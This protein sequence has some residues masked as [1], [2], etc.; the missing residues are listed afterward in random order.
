LVVAEIPLYFESDRRIAEAEVWV[1]YVDQETQVKRLMER[2][3][4]T[5]QRPEKG[6][7]ANCASFQCN[8]ADRVINNTGSKQETWHK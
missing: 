3:A 2:D 6:Y 1:V 8:W 7:G 5:E 4:L